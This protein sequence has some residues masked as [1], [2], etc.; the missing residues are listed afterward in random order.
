MNRIRSSLSFSPLVFARTSLLWSFHLKPL[1]MSLVKTLTSL[2]VTSRNSNSSEGH[3]LQLPRRRR[4]RAVLERHVAGPIHL[5]GLHASLNGNFEA[6]KRL[7]LDKAA[8]LA[9]LG[10]LCVDIVLNV[11][12]LPPPN[13]DERNNYMDKLASSPPDKVCCIFSYSP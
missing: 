4:R 1:R 12:S 8:D 7:V 9:T 2:P 10:N 11:P 13:R 3:V 5:S 6:S